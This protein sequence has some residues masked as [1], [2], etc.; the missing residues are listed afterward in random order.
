MGFTQGHIASRFYR[1][2]RLGSFSGGCDVV[3]L[4]IIA[5]NMQLI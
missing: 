2:S 3:M 5:N 1:D 4:Q